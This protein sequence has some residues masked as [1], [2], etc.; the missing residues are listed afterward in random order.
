M[1]RLLSLLSRYVNLAWISPKN[2]SSRSITVKLLGGTLES[3]LRKNLSGGFVSEIL[4]LWG[5][6]CWGCRCCECCC[7]CCCCCSKSYSGAA[8]F[9]ILVLMEFKNVLTRFHE[10]IS[11]CSWS[12]T[13]IRAYLRTWPLEE[14]S[15]T[16]NTSPIAAPK[17]PGSDIMSGVE[18]LNVCSDDSICRHA[19]LIAINL[20][21]SPGYCVDKYA[22]GEPLNTEGSD[23]RVRMHVV[24]KGTW[25]GNVRRHELHSCDLLKP[26]GKSFWLGWPLWTGATSP[27]GIWDSAWTGVRAWVTRM[28][29][30]PWISQKWLRQS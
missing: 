24:F 10:P 1:Y 30:G 13:H 7:C 18:S 14:S 4:M 6:G 5:C 16:L 15:W 21:P 9:C 2:W 20:L 26:K 12:H 23:L 17:G 8:L 19:C 25:W 22:T 29:V 27:C 3:R 11:N 28:D